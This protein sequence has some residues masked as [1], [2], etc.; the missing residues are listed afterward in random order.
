MVEE[1][2]TPP[3]FP[4]VG[5]GASAGGLDAYKSFLNA[6]P[7]DSGLAFVLVQ[8][9]D[10]THESL[11][12][13]LL[14]RCT[15]MSVVQASD[16]QAV[17]PDH[18]YMI[19]P[20][21]SLGIVDGRLTLSEP[22]ERRGM[23]MAIDTFFRALAEDQRER[24]V[25]VVLSG[26]GTDGTQGLRAIK[27]QG[28]FTLAQ[29]PDTATHDGMPRSAIDAGAVDQVCT[30]ERMPELLVRY[31]DHPHVNGERR[32]PALDVD[33]DDD[34][35]LGAIL[36]L[37][38]ARR[39]VDFR[40][41]K[42]ATLARRI[43]RR[44]GLQHIDE[45]SEYLDLLREQPREVES[46]GKDLMIGVTAFFRDPDVFESLSKHVL[47]PL[48]ARAGNNDTLR[49]WV[50]GCATGEE[51]Y[52][53]AMLLEEEMQAQER[54][55]AMQ[56]F[57]SDI[58]EGALEIARAGEYPA[59]SASELSPERLD[60]FF[61][62]G[63][64]DRLTIR[65]TL[66]EAVVFARQN[67]IADPPFSRLD[68]ISCRNLM[69]Y[70]RQ[71]VQDKLIRLFHFALKSDGAL[72]LGSSEG[73]GRLSE[74]FEPHDKSRRL[75]RR[76]NV[77]AG[78]D[79][80]P[81]L[82]FSTSKESRPPSRTT[83]AEEGSARRPRLADLAGRWVLEAYAP[84]TVIVNRGFEAL[85]F[86][87]P[88]GRY[89]D[90][91]Y[92]EANLNLLEI[93]REG[94][95]TRLRGAIQ[96]GFERGETVTVER[97]RMRHEDRYRPVRVEV[98]PLEGR[99]HA[100]ENLAMVSFTDV[101]DDDDARDTAGDGPDRTGA[102]ESLVRQL[103][104]E[105]G[106]TKQDLQ[107]TIEE[108][109]TS[110][111]ELK[112]SNEEVMSINEELQST[113]EELETSKEELQSLNEELSTVNS[114][115][116]DK[117]GE[118]E[119]AH[120]D[121][122]NLLDSADIATLF[123]DPSLRI[124]RFTPAAVQLFSLIPSDIG[125]PLADVATRLDDATLLEDAHRVL[126]K[127]T[128]IELEVE[129]RAESGSDG[130]WFTRRILPY[131]TQ[132]DRIDGVVLT[133]NEVT[134][135]RSSE[136]LAGERLAQLEGIYR[137]MPVGLAFHDR[138][139]RFRL[140]NEPLAA[141]NGFTVAAHIG[142][143]PCELLPGEFGKRV[144]RLLGEV[145]ES[146]EA[147]DGVEIRAATSREPGVERDW[148]ASYFPVSA[149]DGETLGVNVVVQE[150][151][152]RKQAERRLVLRD[153]IA[154]SLTEA[155]IGETDEADPLHAVMP[156]LL[157]AFG[158]A[159]GAD[160]AEYWTP[161]RE[162][163]A[164]ACSVFRAP[165]EPARHDELKRRF[166]DVLI[167]PGVG[168]IG[169][170]W[171]ERGP[172]WLADATRDPH[173]G[174]AGAAASLG[175]GT[176][177]A[178]PVLIDDALLGETPLGVISA[179][180]RK[181]QAA[182]PELVPMLAEVGRELGA[183]VGRRRAEQ[184]LRVAIEATGA[185]LYEHAEPLDASTYHS[186]RCGAMLGFRPEELPPHDTFVNWAFERTHPQD[187]DR[188]VSAYAA[189]IGGETP[190]YEV[191]MRLR[192]R[193]GSW[194]WVRG[195]SRALARDRAGRVTR[196]AGLML[197]VSAQKRVEEEVV[198]ERNAARDRERE[199]RALTDHMP[200]IVTRFDRDYRHV[201]VNPAVTVATGRPPEEY[202]GRSNRELGM[203]EALC[204]RW[205][206]MIDRV[207]DEGVGVEG[208]F[209]F[210]GPHGMR[211]YQ[212]RLV[213]ER[214]AEGKVARV[215]GVTTDITERRRAEAAL[216]ERERRLERVVQELDAVY[217]TA[218]V[219]LCVLDRE[220]RVLKINEHLA[221]IGGQPVEAHIGRRGGELYPTLAQELDA[222][223]RRVFDT[224]EP[225]LHHEIGAPLTPGDASRDWLV[226]YVPLD[227]EDD[228]VVTVS[229]T[230]IEITE[231]K[232]VERVM[233]DA[234]AKADAANRS[235]SEFLAN[236]SHEIRSPLTAVL[237]YADLLAARLR[238]PEDLDSI[239]AIRLNG[240]HLLALLNDFLD[241]AKIESGKL[242]I[243][244][245]TVDTAALL[246]EIVALMAP[247]AEAKRLAFD[248]ECAGALPPTIHTDPVRL[249]QILIN[250]VSNAIKFT[251]EGQVRVVASLERDGDGDGSSALRFDVIDTGIGLTRDQRR[252]L[253]EPFTQ[254]DSSIT[255]RYGGSGLGLTISRRLADL[256]GGGVTI[257]S[258]RR[259][260]SAF[261]VT[262]DPGPIDPSTLV[263]LGDFVERV[264]IDDDGFRW[265]PL[266]GRILVVDDR[267]DVRTLL[268]RHLERAGLEVV[269]VAG[270][271]AAL[272]AV[273]AAG[274]D[275]VDGTGGPFDAVIMDMQMPELD[276][277]ETTRQLRSDGFERPIIALTAA[278]LVGTRERCLEAGCDDYLTKPL[279]V[280][281]LR[282]TL[283]RH[284][285]AAPVPPVPNGA[286]PRVLLV[287]DNEDA[288][289]ATAKLLER[290]GLEVRT[291]T[292]GHGA[293]DT[294]A[295]WEPQ[296]VLLDLYLPDIDG[297]EVATRLRAASAPPVLIA[298][299]GRAEGIGGAG[300]P[301]DH[302]LVKPA[303]LSELRR[304][305]DRAVAADDR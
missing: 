232:H 252:Q 155:A 249:R 147:K 240:Q 190:G 132:D 298:L 145:L 52:T 217:R 6:M 3:A 292:D 21:R 281:R 182:D 94:L 135:L 243:E 227:V 130:R 90:Y 101:K 184:R 42:R 74:L 257:D 245:R 302:H 179:F 103:E 244:R 200:D 150:I 189:F 268:R 88:V 199:Y 115:L 272:A 37:L 78:A 305:I 196:V 282:E 171:R 233:R 253:F 262:V 294:A 129:T 141:I 250:L 71:P 100:G 266:R 173:F 91:P 25:G 239:G 79:A 87:G 180:T 105:L 237:G 299:T 76:V 197:D 44:M 271:S 17:E 35:G 242:D 7:P 26:T 84:A 66:R 120:N 295:R 30:I 222:V 213:P 206:R 285:E 207:F 194:V 67:L 133:F 228:E 177:L 47:G 251:A 102:E 125:R 80:V 286:P 75:Y 139:R 259:R 122:T 151:T 276:G 146:G 46:L 215:L 116:Q 278:A 279:D 16:D 70:L 72:L 195:Y 86:C 261:S 96:R 137:D 246:A 10:P 174:R 212:S 98:R 61:D 162:G 95:V 226:S 235:K 92:G 143:T 191:E 13:D 31:A 277:Y 187:R 175:L 220:L 231:R 15:E 238:E 158:R 203:P 34:T 62:K 290:A 29:E 198:A 160:I 82:P 123:L 32:K 41:Y 201:Y 134:R 64:G 12:A 230:V 288:L 2:K 255:R 57:A 218:P 181:R 140:V 149:D 170:V 93:A 167:E 214:D 166:D 186:P 73:I 188:L 51:A 202:L 161:G 234:R 210:E 22:V 113:N 59:G 97:V 163:G 303:R 27:A 219:G 114:Q 225:V 289:G 54:R 193:D 14:G 131:R 211:H 164:L 127:L 165:T 153:A 264:A 304:L 58:D 19:P 148:L 254:A 117:I 247:H 1:E 293:L 49:V 104:D 56:V 229:G 48:V 121:L 223:I 126:R 263:D 274:D 63:K 53:I 60:A 108:M 176:G 38:L 216:E 136:R 178:L 33:S 224:G 4:I 300:S 109:E 107:T 18:V 267:D 111:E 260:G 128:P 24:A 110:N 77:A 85:F 118:L 291:A 144:E 50:P 265:A 39:G 119:E 208:D 154:R 112:A 156:A 89:L 172:R 11:M 157:D 169:E 270:G 297:H 20:N 28:G 8:H 9:L 258:R 43:E 236:M 142:R 301:F 269:D 106:A 283:S 280:A 5:I 99:A 204:E 36:A 138:E 65:K 256:L 152:A 273:R 69:I 275:A 205:E 248:I 287:D 192:H 183:W 185:A 241:L 83:A 55:V 45:P 296:V 23:R 221:R 284:L 159:F 81:T 168:L 209:A 124:K 40:Q 68:L